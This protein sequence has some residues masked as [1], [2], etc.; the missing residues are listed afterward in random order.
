MSIKNTFFVQIPFDFW[1]DTFAAY[2][3]LIL[4]RTESYEIQLIQKS[5]PV[6][7]SE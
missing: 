1:E 7:M 3:E 6:D 2:S 4:C 5:V